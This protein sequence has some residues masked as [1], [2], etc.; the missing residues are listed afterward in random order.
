MM[1]MKNVMK[2]KWDLISLKYGTSFFYFNMYIFS[3]YCSKLEFHFF[4]ILSYRCRCFCFLF[5]EITKNIKLEQVK[6]REVDGVI[7]S[8]LCT[9]I[10]RTF[11]MYL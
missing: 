2:L 6:G 8:F 9:A 11:Y 4:F 7:S 1:M 5:T 3:D 10:F